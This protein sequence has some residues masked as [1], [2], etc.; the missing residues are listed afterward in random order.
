VRGLCFRFCRG[1]GGRRLCCHS[2]Q[3]RSVGRY[4]TLPPHLC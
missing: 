1:W 3:A 4:S 2:W